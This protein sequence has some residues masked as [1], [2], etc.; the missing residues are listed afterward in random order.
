MEAFEFLLNDEKEDVGRIFVM[1]CMYCTVLYQS[2]L[3]A[4][5]Q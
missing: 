3:N 2:V 1:A 4:N 5:L